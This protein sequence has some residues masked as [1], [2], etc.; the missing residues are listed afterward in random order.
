MK[1]N[2]YDFDYSNIQSCFE[3][4][5][6]KEN[7]SVFLST[8]IGMLGYPKSKNKNKILTSRKWILEALKKIIGKK[9][10]IFVPTYSYSFTKKVKKF[11]KS[12]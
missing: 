7:D 5:G 1:N 4:L 8:S 11:D 6:L 10:N 12:A 2:M 3:K 9:G